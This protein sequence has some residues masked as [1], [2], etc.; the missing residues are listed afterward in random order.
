MN[1]PDGTNIPVKNFYEEISTVTGGQSLS[2][3]NFN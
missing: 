1:L 2:L 3:D